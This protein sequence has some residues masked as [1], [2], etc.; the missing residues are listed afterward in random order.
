M[1]SVA[2]SEISFDALPT[3]TPSRPIAGSA[4]GEVLAIASVRIARYIV[5]LPFL[6]EGWAHRDGASCACLADS[7]LPSEK[8]HS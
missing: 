7:R 8:N 2:I 6:I 1:Q 4:K 5:S 3:G